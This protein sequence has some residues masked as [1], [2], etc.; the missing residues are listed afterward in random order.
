MYKQHFEF[1]RHSSEAV[2]C[3]PHFVDEETKPGEGTCLRTQLG[4]S[5]ASTV[6][7]LWTSGHTGEWMVVFQVGG[8]RGDCDCCS[9]PRPGEV[10]MAP[11]D[12]ASVSAHSSW[13]GAE[14][15]RGFPSPETAT[16]RL[17]QK[18]AIEEPRK[19]T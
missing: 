15:G 17:G 7:V 10:Q 13:L 12:R 2:Y 19:D 5:R 14:E 4:N 8:Q 18:C 9:L 16:R 11:E 3:Y 6:A 1:I